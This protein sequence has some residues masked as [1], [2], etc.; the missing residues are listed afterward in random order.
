MICPRT[1]HL[2][3]ADCEYRSGPQTNYW[4]PTAIIASFPV[5]ISTNTF[6]IYETNDCVAYGK[7]IGPPMGTFCNFPPLCFC[8]GE[9]CD[10]AS[11]LRRS[12]G[13]G[14]PRFQYDTLVN[15]EYYD[16]SDTLSRSK[17]LRSAPLY[18]AIKPNRSDV[19][20]TS[21][22]GNDY[23]SSLGGD[24]YKVHFQKVARIPHFS[25]STNF[26]TVALYRSFDIRKNRHGEFDH[27][28][29]R[30]FGVAIDYELTDLE[31]RNIR[32]DNGLIEIISLTDSANVKRLSTET[33]HEIAVRVATTAPNSRTRTV[34]KYYHV[35]GVVSAP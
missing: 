13:P 15:D 3:S 20:P 17:L 29:D 32:E 24:H 16:G 9:D 10:V 35:Y 34:R 26:L 22:A 2:E 30:Y 11:F 4:C 19:L 25:G 27:E 12:G 5:V 28:S 18:R 8:N 7:P 33:W 1:A 23:M 31:S 14:A 21:A 6:C